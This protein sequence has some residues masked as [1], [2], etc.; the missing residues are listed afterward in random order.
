MNK[1]TVISGKLETKFVEK[2]LLD[3]LLCVVMSLWPLKSVSL[4]RASCPSR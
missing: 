1:D 2:A 4:H 3:C